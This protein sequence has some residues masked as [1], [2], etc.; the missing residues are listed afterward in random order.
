MLTILLA[1]IALIAQPQPSGARAQAGPIAAGP[2]QQ[3]RVYEIFD[4]NRTAFHERFRDHATRIMARHGFRILAMW[5][6]RAADR[7][8]FVYLLDWPDEEAMKRAWKDFLADPEWVRI[9]AE[10][11]A[12][13]GQFV[14][15]IEESV[16]RRVN[17]GPQPGVPALQGQASQISPQQP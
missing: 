14:G 12:R 10:T 2:I 6:G 13:H 5:E 3:L 15:N 9:K 7:P 16:M 17:Y 11:A 8:Q 1:G 4:G